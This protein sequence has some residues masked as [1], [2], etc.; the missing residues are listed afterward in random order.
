MLNTTPQRLPNVLATVCHE[1][2]V[3]ATAVLEG[4]TNNQPVVKAMAATITM[5]TA[6]A[7]AMVMPLQ[8]QWQRQGKWPPNS[9]GNGGW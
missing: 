9:N 3:I 7:T 1:H 5:A 4:K 2:V 8:W 6:T